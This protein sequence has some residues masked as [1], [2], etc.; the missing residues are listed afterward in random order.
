MRIWIL[1]K[2]SNTHT[3]TQLIEY[4]KYDLE[5]FFISWSFSDLNH[6]LKRVYE[7]KTTADCQNAFHNTYLHVINLKNVL[8]KVGNERVNVTP[9]KLNSTRSKETLNS[10]FVCR[11]LLIRSSFILVDCHCLSLH[12]VLL[13]VSRFEFVKFSCRH[14]IFGL[15]LHHV[16][17]WRLK[18]IVGFS[19]HLKSHGIQVYDNKIFY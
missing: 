11:L 8:M 5:F 4:E 12:V 9:D 10:R 18:T 3:H 2:I 19:T 17:R 6:N 7:F 13:L 14:A 15:L 1:Y 16:Q